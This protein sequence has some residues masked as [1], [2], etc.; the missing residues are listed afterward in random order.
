MKYLQYAVET[1]ERLTTIFHYSL[2]DQ[3]IRA[4]SYHP[5]HILDRDGKLSPS[6]L[7]PFCEF[8]GSMALMGTKISQFSLPVCTSFEPKVLN[9]QLCYEVDVDKYKRKAAAEG[10][11]SLELTLL[12]D[13][14][15]EW[16]I[17][18]TERQKNRRSGDNI[19]EI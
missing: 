3:H 12:I 5:P 2:D 8:G 7:I 9:D 13:S 14:N 18:S 1:R 17:T 16:F 4:L 6:A 10:I 11:T 15:K 19:G